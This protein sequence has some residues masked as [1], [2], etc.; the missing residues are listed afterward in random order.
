MDVKGRGTLSQCSVQSLL[1]SL[2]WLLHSANQHSTLRSAPISTYANPCLGAQC[3]KNSPHLWLPFLVEEK[4][5]FSSWKYCI[6]LY[7]T[8]KKHRITKKY[9]H[10]IRI[11]MELNHKFSQTC[12]SWH[13]LMVERPLKLNKQSYVL[14]PLSLLVLL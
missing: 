2:T 7:Y 13:G 14:N 4:G 3:C 8:Y 10:H 12:V 5:D 1:G 9:V 6:N 11:Y